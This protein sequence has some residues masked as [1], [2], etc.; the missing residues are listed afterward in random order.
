MCDVTY[1]VEEY[2]Y[3]SYYGEQGKF[4]NIDD[5]IKRVVE[6]NYMKSIDSN[7]KENFY[8]IE[9]TFDITKFPIDPLSKLKID[10]MYNSVTDVYV[11]DQNF[12]IDFKDGTTKCVE[13]NGNM[14]IFMDLESI[15]IKSGGK[16]DKFYPSDF[17]G[18]KY[19]EKNKCVFDGVQEFI[20]INES[21]FK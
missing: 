17:T 3:G 16:F 20:S 5:A 7:M 14:I 12:Y 18:K 21:N 4:T 1:I 13:R 2:A 11:L 10:K 19:L 15:I 9:L 8:K 6:L